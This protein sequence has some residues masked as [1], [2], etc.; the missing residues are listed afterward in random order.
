M[1]SRDD[2]ILGRPRQT[3]KILLPP[4]ERIIRQ[5]RTSQRLTQTESLNDPQPPSNIPNPGEYDTVDDYVDSIVEN[6]Y[7]DLGW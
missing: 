4:T 6:Y 1:C 7:E 5:M 2:E 3:R